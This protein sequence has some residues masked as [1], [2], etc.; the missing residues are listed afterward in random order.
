MNQKIFIE[1]CV[2]FLKIYGPYGR[3][4]S[5]YRRSLAHAR[6]MFL[7]YISYIQAEVADCQLHRQCRI[8]VG[9]VGL[10]VHLRILLILV[11]K[12]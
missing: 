3:G 11:S 12:R 8:S 6:E 5:S 2:G 1:I 4:L 9:S 10:M 7:S